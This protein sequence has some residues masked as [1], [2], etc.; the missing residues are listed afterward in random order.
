MK[1][2]KSIVGLLAISSFFLF[3]TKE[4]VLA[5]ESSSESTPA[6]ERFS[7]ENISKSLPKDTVLIGQKDGKLSDIMSEQTP[8]SRIEAVW[9]HSHATY[10]SSKGVSI[11][12]ELYLPS[13][14]NPKFTGMFGTASAYLKNDSKSKGFSKNANGTKTISTTVSTGAK[15][16]SKERGTANF[17]G[18]A[19]AQNALGGGGGFSS[20]Y[21]ITIP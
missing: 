9:Y 1:L 2:I 4:I 19:T 16:K 15:G 8:T 20:S 3:S 5:T 13:G 17:S 10:S 7:A 21:S 11:Y 6:I 12:I 18:I 14:G